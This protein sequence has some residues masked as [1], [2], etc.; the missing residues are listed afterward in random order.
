M[1]TGQTSAA[2]ILRY[3][4][5]SI[6]LHWI[7]AL[8]VIT[9]WSLGQTI[10]LFPKGTPRV[11]ARSTHI[12]LGALLGLVLLYRGFWRLTAGRSL[13]PPGTAIWRAVARLG[14]AALYLV[15]AT[16]VALGIA[17]A[18]LRGDNLFNWFTLPAFEP[19]NTPLTESVEDLH[20]LSA[21]TVLV[22]AGLHALAALVHHYAL[23]D[24]TL[25]RMLPSGRSQVP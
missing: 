5:R 20:A 18:W 19:G 11:Y 25:L 2:A 9:L 10:D 3:D 12:S 7:T 1:T 13:A 14:H 6:W 17:N 8:L 22:L 21:N 16:T 15:L 24:G 23:K 4:P